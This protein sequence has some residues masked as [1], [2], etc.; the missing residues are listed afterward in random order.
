[1]RGARFLLPLFFLSA[2]SPRAPAETTL[3]HRSPAT[4]PEQTPFD[5]F[6]QHAANALTRST[7]A[8]GR[9][10][11]P[12]IAHNPNAGTQFGVLPVWIF[13]D[14]KGQIRDIIAPMLIYNPTL[15]PMFSG[16]YYHYP[17]EN[18][19]I[20]VLAE[21]AVR[22]DYRLSALY[23]GVFQERFAFNAEANFQAD[24][25]N[26]FYGVGPQTAQSNQTNYNLL[27]RLARF[28]SGAFLGDWLFAAGW[29]LRR[30]QVMPSVYPSP[31]P[32]DP[33][34]QTIN[35]YS[36]PM[37]RIA[38]DTR[39]LRY[40]PS[41]GSFLEGFA[42]YSDAAWGSD[43]SY[44]RY[45]GQWRIYLPTTA[46]ATTVLHAQ[47]EWT[48]GRVPFTALA[49]L[50]GARSLRGFPEGRF[51]DKGMWFANVEE[52]Y[53]IHSFVA[54]GSTTEFQVAPFFELGEVAPAIDELRG[55][56]VQLVEGVAFRAVVKPTVVGKVELGIGR[57]G[58]N[59]FVGIDYPF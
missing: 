23:D 9:V 52:R 17:A 32:V 26:Q 39:D 20:R 11:F 53:N 22:A 44:R 8:G 13:N 27:E 58:M 10:Y 51:Q 29:R 38:R 15:G 33:G 36:L 28:E 46:K 35:F 50:G 40:T 1:M 31:R 2:L 49:A 56:L 45:G 30:T 7:A 25:T 4:E 18:S 14:G 57:E 41:T 6:L 5:R 55:R 3:E 54:A 48:N 24:P 12:V 34:L 16:T 37:V 59:L 42:E 21:K 19:K 47:S 43:L